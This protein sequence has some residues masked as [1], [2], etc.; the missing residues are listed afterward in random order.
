ML[1]KKIITSTIVIITLV[2]CEKKVLEIIPNDRISAVGAFSTPTK[3][4][5]AVLGGYNALQSAN[6]L[7]GR[8]LIYVDLLAEDTYDRTLFFGDIARYT[9]LSNNAVAAGVWNA[10]YSTI[11]TANRNAENV[12]AN[13]GIITAAKAK[14]LV[15]ECLFVR[16]VSHFY[17]VNFFAQPYN[18][19]PGATHIGIPIITENFTTNDPAANKPRATV[20]AVYSSI[21]NDLTTALA[22]LPA[23][24]STVYATKT[25]ATKAAAAALLAR[26]HL[27]KEDY[28][29]AKL[30]SQNIINGQFGTF[31][32]RPTP[33]GAFGPG[34]YQTNETIWSIPSNVSDNPGTNN[35][36]PQHYSGAGRADLPVSP[37][38]LSINTNPYFALDDRRRTMIANGVGAASSTL[39]TTKY[40]DV[41]TRADWAPIIRYAEVL[42]I[43]AE[44]SANIAT[45]VD[46]DAVTKLNMVRDRSRIS[47][48]QYSVL[49]FANKTMLLDAIIGERRIELAYEGHR[50]WDLM[51]TKR[52][53]SNKYDTDGIAVL[54]VLTPGSNKAV[55]PIPQTEI[56][57]SRNV[58][59]QNPGY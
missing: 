59:V 54:P 36:L 28:A 15:A 17:L 21:I 43:N 44:A 29:N 12:S 25:R 32:L 3:I 56:D 38:F 24:Y 22:D 47:A 53:V 55:F 19:T 16:A 51:R 45:G 26:V 50:F 49:S 5:N 57:K 34:N 18:F 31:A 1:F 11:V 7:S 30:V 48:P 39:Y 35:A 20:A 8:A 6:F 58:L 9:M 13:V 10:G 40:P 37:S 4:E 46:P 2:S 33:N 27:Y 42:L 52:S 41:A 14:E 23:S